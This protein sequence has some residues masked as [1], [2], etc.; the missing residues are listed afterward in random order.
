MSQEVTEITVCTPCSCGVDHGRRWWDCRTSMDQIRYTWHGTWEVTAEM[1]A[2]VIARH[3][4][5]DLRYI[6]PSPAE[7]GITP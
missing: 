5:S 1:V 6:G 2:Y 3:P 7:L 4:D